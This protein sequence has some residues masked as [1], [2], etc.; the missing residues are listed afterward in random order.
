MSAERGVGLGHHEHPWIGLEVVDAASG[1]TGLLRAVCPEPNGKG[2]PVAW[3]LPPGGG[4]EWTT[5]LGAIQ[6]AG[7]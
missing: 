3:L 7:E 1:R 4:M 6:K 2:A 5:H